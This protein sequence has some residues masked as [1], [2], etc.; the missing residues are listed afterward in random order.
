M[1]KN[2]CSSA[3]SFV[4][5]FYYAPPPPPR[6]LTRASK[7]P[8]CTARGELI[9]PAGAARCTD[10]SS[11]SLS[12]SLS[13]WLSLSVQCSALFSSRPAATASRE[14][15]VFHSGASFT[16]FPAY[17]SFSPRAPNSS[18]DRTCCLF[19]SPLQLLCY[20]CARR[21][22][23]AGKTSGVIASCRSLAQITC[24]LHYA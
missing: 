21:F 9:R 18:G 10:C 1:D 20:D 17:G 13:L 19:P 7:G 2:R 15:A 23:L 6:L 14:R 8:L 11:L 3:G 24:P 12:L 5:V 4:R 22:S 16:A